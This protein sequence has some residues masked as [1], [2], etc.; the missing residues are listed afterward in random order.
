VICEQIGDLNNFAGLKKYF[1]TKSGPELMLKIYYYYS[2][3]NRWA[4]KIS[5]K[6][7]LHRMSAFLYEKLKNLSG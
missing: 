6:I 3:I 2:K 1:R 7:G 4:I 5:F